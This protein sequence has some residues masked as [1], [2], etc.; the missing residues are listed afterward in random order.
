MPSHLMKLLI[1]ATIC[2]VATLVFICISLFTQGWVEVDVT[3]I[4][5]QVTGSSGIFPWKCVS[6]G[7]CNVFWNT[8]D[9]WDF[10]F[11]FLML[12]AWIFQIAALITAFVA[13]LVPRHRYK[14]MHQFC[15]TQTLITLFLIV[16]L[17]LYGIEYDRNLGTLNYIPGVSVSLAYSYWLCLV[18]AIFSVVTFMIAGA[19]TKRARHH[20]CD[21]Y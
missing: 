1:G 14:F 21:Y 9:G 3:E 7:T 18:A 19:A 5:L 4:G 2:A 20:G 15:G 13:L 10:T 16:E 8:A 17:I 12:F 6:A 11:F